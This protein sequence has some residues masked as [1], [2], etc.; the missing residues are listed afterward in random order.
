MKNLKSFI[1]NIIKE[2]LNN[3]K[4]ELPEYWYHGTNKYFEKFTLDNMGKNWKQSDLGI[5]FTQYIKPG[6]YGSTAKEYAEDLVV[7]EGGK[8]YIYKC[9]I[10]TNNPLI[11]NSNGWYSSNTYIDKNRNNIKRWM[12]TDNNDCVISYNFENKKEEGLQWGDYILAT[13][14]L[15]IIQ[16][17]D[18]FEFNNNTLKEQT[19]DNNTY[20]Y[21]GT[22][23]GQ[24]LNIQKDAYMKPNNTW[25]P[26]DN[27]N[28]IFDEPLFMLNEN[29]YTITNDEFGNHMVYKKGD[30]KIL[31]N[32]EISPTN[33][34]LWYD[35]YKGWEKVGALTVN[36]SEVR[37]D[38]DTD[39]QKYYKISEIEIKPQHRNKG[40]GKLMYNI[41][42]EMRGN[43]IKG[44][45]S[46]LP[47][48]VN[49]TQIPS[50]YKHYKTIIEND[51]Q[52][53]LF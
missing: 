28:V 53:I 45:Y 15:N 42:I 25:K 37:F 4:H 47:D 19:I 6:I 1:R 3:Q 43:N 48:R 31:V 44:L 23:K 14:N 46:Y 9:K 22:A 49:K 18:I 38:F 51:F 7:R 8:P 2:E 41:L 24:A 39:F 34:T 5:Y 29:K 35:N 30:Y 27:W 52:I 36:V 11:L 10:H 26:L 16:I 50:I 12:T 13:N 33:I 32:S 20:I 17:I 21:H 40:F